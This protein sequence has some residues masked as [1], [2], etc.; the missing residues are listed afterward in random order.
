MVLIV[1]A[2]FLVLGGAVL[3]Y[4]TVSAYRTRAQT[5]DQQA[6]FIARS[7]VSSTIRYIQKD[8]AA[9]Q[10]IAALTPGNATLTGRYAFP[11]QAVSG[12][13]ET[14]EITAT[15]F[16]NGKP[17]VVRVTASAAQN[18]IRASA[19]AYLKGTYTAPSDSGS[20]HP[21]DN[22]LY[23]NGSGGVGQCTLYGNVAADGDFTFGQSTSLNGTLLAN[24]KVTL[25]GNGSGL[26][27]VKT[28]GDVEITGSGL[29]SNGDVYA[30]GSMVISGAG[31]VNGSVYIQKTGNLYGS[32][33]ISRNAQFGGNVSISGGGQRI[34]GNLTTA[35][36]VTFSNNTQSAFV[37]GNVTQG[38]ALAPVKVDFSRMSQ[39]DRAVSVPPI[40]NV[41]TTGEKIY[42]PQVIDHYTI[43]D[44]CVLNLAAS[45]MGTLTFDTTQKDIRVVINSSQHFTQN[46]D[47]FVTGPHRLLIYLSG[48]GTT[49]TIEHR[50]MM[51]QDYPNDTS[52]T[53]Q[54]F[55]MGSGEAGQTV[56]LTS[57]PRVDA[58]IYLPKGTVNIGG[59]Q[60]GD[61]NLR[62]SIC[63]GT[64]NISGSLTLK[65]CAPSDLTGTPLEGLASDGS[66]G[67]SGG[68]NGSGSTTTWTWTLDG[69]ADK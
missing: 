39:L 57:T 60:E 68:S 27:G 4:G 41:V 52:A 16:S 56:T 66:G 5:D 20:V 8:T 7:A 25:N 9:Q 55:I 24:G 49:L 14:V 13:A 38:A 22:L 18:E 43:A 50:F 33:N 47:V 44:D 61:Y 32:G 26:L 12:S 15:R 59:G 69:W 10:K 67:G 42:W 54:I 63:A 58:Y 1:F 48:A 28:T 19:T 30:M 53:P 36:T 34:T 65:Y 35:G 21:L 23:F 37:G 3:T 29:V 6:Y 62:G 2:V 51:Q 64:E 31:K 45:P 11:E 40:S 17:S 46:I